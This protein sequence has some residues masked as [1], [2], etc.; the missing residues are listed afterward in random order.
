[1]KL[2][3]K[4]GVSPAMFWGTIGIG[5]ASTAASAMALTSYA[6]AGM[7]VSILGAV[8]MFVRQKSGVK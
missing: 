6:W 2:Q 1:M 7:V 8:V 5:A 3:L 4:E